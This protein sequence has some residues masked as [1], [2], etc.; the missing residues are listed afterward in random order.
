MTTP[1]HSALTPVLDARKELSSPRNNTVIATF[2]EV[3]KC[4]T[5][6]PVDSP[7]TGT[8]CASLR[9]SRPV[10][11][12]SSSTADVESAIGAPAAGGASGDWDLQGEQSDP[13]GTA[14]GLDP[15]PGF[16]V[17]L[18]D[19]LVRVLS[20]SA[21]RLAESASGSLAGVPPFVDQWGRFVRRLAW[22]GDGRRGTARIE[23]AAGE[24]AGAAIVVHAVERQV[25][26]E[27]DLPEGVPL[28]SW[29]ERIAA[30]LRERGVE[31]LELSIR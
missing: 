16:G 4:Q 26:I 21:L 3:L 9:S 2:R 13:T 14:P 20:S 30:R 11:E 5:G 7:F 6:Q 24:W 19:P 8:R 28:E 31:L 22:G 18:N 17:E 29:R 1:V 27:I 23:I 10:S 12:A 25:R 15:S